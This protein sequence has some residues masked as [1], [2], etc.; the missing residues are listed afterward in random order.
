[1]LFKALDISMVQSLSTF[2]RHTWICLHNQRSITIIKELTQLTQAG[3][4]SPQLRFAIFAC[5]TFVCALELMIV[6]ARSSS[7]PSI[8][9]RCLVTGFVTMQHGLYICGRQWHSCHILDHWGLFL[10]VYKSTTR[11][12]RMAYT[13]LQHWITNLFAQPLV[14]NEVHA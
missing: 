4:V 1:M 8:I 11:M 10:G 7:E 3:C 9:M 5:M 13:K 14:R 6:T 12:P 2:Y